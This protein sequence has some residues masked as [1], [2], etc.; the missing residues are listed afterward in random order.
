MSVA[1]WMANLNNNA[2]RFFIAV[3][4]II[5]SVQCSLAFGGFLS[6]IAPSVNIALAFAG[7]VLVPLMIFS[8]FLLSFE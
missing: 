1:Y 5:L 2:D 3:A 6:V 4:I 8:G 7:P